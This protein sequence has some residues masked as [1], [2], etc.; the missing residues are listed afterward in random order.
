MTAWSVS[1]RSPKPPH[2]EAFISLA[3]MTVD[4]EV[5][6]VFEF[7]QAYLSQKKVRSSGYSH[8]RGTHP[9]LRRHSLN[10]TPSLTTSRK[11]SVSNQSGT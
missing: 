1:F 4:L 7:H 6:N 5:S 11:P 9:G 8:F 2:V 3:E 10:D